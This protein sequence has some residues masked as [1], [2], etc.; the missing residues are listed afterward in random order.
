MAERKAERTFLSGVLTLACSTMLVKVI[1]FLYK[2]PMLSY[3]GAEGMGYFHSAYE[4]YAL[5]CIVSTAGLPIALSVLISA[6]LAKGDTRGAERIWRVALGVFVGIGVIGCCAMAALTPLFCRL[7]KSENAYLCLLAISP[8]VLF[9]CL[10]SALRGY[11]QGHGQM[12]QTAISQLI[13][14]IGKLAFGLI[15]ADFASEHGWSLPRVAAMAGV[16]LTLGSLLSA[17]YLIAEKCRF[18]TDCGRVGTMRTARRGILSQ[19]VK[20]AFPM[21]LGASAVSLTKLVDM[22]M[23]LRRLQSVGYSAVEANAAYGSYTT[24]ALSVYSLVPTLLSSVSLP[25]VPLLSAA[26]TAGEQVRQSALIRATYRLTALVAIPASVGLSA[27]AQPILSLLFGTEPD[28]VSQAAP[29]LSLLG[30][31]VFL[32]CMIGAT[33]SVLHAYRA[34]SLPILSLLVGAVVKVVSAYLFIGSPKIGILGAP[35]STLLCNA[36][37][38]G[39]N[40]YFAAR[41]CR[42]RRLGEVF[43]K[44]LLSAALSVG[45]AAVCYRLLVRRLGAHAWLTVCVLGVCVVFYLIFGCLSGG[46]RADDLSALPGGAALCRALRCF[47]LLPRQESEQER[48]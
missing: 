39:M 27:F 31:S 46:V 21:T 37:V 28:A 8:T 35:I 20:L 25:L 47:G 7:I 23:I 9:V 10:S 26:I 11:F 32:S 41:F 1:G 5:F 42:V 29:L 36:A 38:V 18:R 12:S 6:A 22:A 14:A 45:I 34:V 30:T 3:L 4:L 13:E 33:N 40:L 2:I 19:L 17:L 16:G 48:S 15:L 43:G 44:P 24:L